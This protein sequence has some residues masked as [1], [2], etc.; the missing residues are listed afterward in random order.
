MQAFVSYAQ[1]QV[2]SAG[3][4]GV[5]V[6]PLG[7][8]GEG[9]AVFRVSYLSANSVWTAAARIYFD[10]VVN[11][12]ISYIDEGVDQDSHSVADSLDVTYKAG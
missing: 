4:T 2:F 6:S 3:G 11:K 12:M 7:N 9:T 8:T 10:I 1:G 5:R